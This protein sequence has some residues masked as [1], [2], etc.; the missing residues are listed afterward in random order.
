[1]NF[2]GLLLV[3]LKAKVDGG[4]YHAEREYDQINPGPGPFVLDK[5]NKADEAD[6]A[7]DDFAWDKF[8]DFFEIEACF[9]F[10]S[11]DFKLHARR[12]VVGCIQVFVE[13]TR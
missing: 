7:S 6:M 11:L 5:W 2:I 10:S 1:M 9:L 13:E 3:R 4:Q 8:R 12:G